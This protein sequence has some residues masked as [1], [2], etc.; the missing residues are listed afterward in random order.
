MSATVRKYGSD[1]AIA[2]L[3]RNLADAMRSR[4]MA[5]ESGTAGL[6]VLKQALDFA[7]L[8]QS[9]YPNQPEQEKLRKS[10][11][12]RKAWLDRRVATLNALASSSQWDVYVL[13]ARDFERFQAAYPQAGKQFQQAMLESRQA[14]GKLAALRKQEGDFAGAYRE[15]RLAS[16][17]QPSDA[18]LREEAMQAWTEYSRRA[19]IDQQ[20]KR[21]ALSAGPRSAVERGLFFADQNRQSKK[22]DDALKNVQEAETILKNSLPPGA[23]SPETLK[24]LFMKAEILAAQER[25]AEALSALDAY[26]LYAVDEERAAADKLRNQILFTLNNYLGTVRTRLASAW[27]EGN[28]PEVSR[29]SVQALKMKGDD[30]D[31]LYYAGVTAIATRQPVEGK[32]L[33]TRYLD[34]SNTLDAKPDDRAKVIRLLPTL[35][36]APA[37]GD[38]V[39]NWLSGWKA[40]AGSFYCPVSLAFLPAI[41]RIEGSGKLRE[42]FEWEGERLKSVTPAIEGGA[43]VSEKKIAFA[44]YDKAGQVAWA[45]DSDA[46][47]PSPENG[48]M[49]LNHPTIDPIAVQRV[50]GKNIALGIAFNRY[51]NP[52]VFEKIYYFRLTYDEQGRVVN[53]RELSGPKGAP[54]EQS[55]EFEWNGT[56]LTAIRGYVGKT[57]NYERTMQYTAGRLM[58]EEIQGQGKASRIKYTYMGNRL[59]S[60]E[61]TNDMTLDNRSR[62]IAFRS[63]SPST[64]VK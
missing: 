22:L 3:E 55:L 51:F 31:I 15:F 32:E 62:K 23:F 9:V 36:A 64:L 44:Y 7:Q 47:K 28:F 5:F 4:Y 37:H 6:D 29:L 38:G 61:S 48:T 42:T 14:H 8:S 35:G 24:T 43:V 16:A 60:A 45:T 21:T 19:A 58:S 18:V 11:N 17:R 52:F 53:A 10:L 30:P 56:Q 41:E 40:P 59:V 54:T 13:A 20:S 33:L 63:G 57:K 46:A 34:V 50:S 25:H 39:P 1:P 2:P 49:L 26:D 27:N 12:E